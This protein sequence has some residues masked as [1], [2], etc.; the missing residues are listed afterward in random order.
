MD[1]THFAEFG[2]LQFVHV[3]IDT[4]SG[5]IFASLHTGENACHFIARFFE[6]WGAW[7]QHKELK[8]DNGSA[9]TSNTF[10]SFCKMMGIHL[11]HSIPYNPQGQG[12]IEHAHHNLKECLMKQKGGVALGATP[13]E[14]LS[15]ALFTLNFLK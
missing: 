14:C 2:K 4:A 11:V 15:I 3:S 5:V 9:Y 6:A 12:I 8:T 13:G 7:G 10:V 1:I